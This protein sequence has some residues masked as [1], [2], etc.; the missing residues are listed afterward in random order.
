MVSP[1]TMASAKTRTNTVT[2]RTP[3]TI[4]NRRFH[5]VFSPP[6]SGKLLSATPSMFLSEIFTEP[7]DFVEVV[8]IQQITRSWHVLFS[9][10]ASEK[11]TLYLIPMTT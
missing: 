3:R 9:I 11:L 2:P 6:L 8:P 4:S 10:L 1:F 7:P 5:P